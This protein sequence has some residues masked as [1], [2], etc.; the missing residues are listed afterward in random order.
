MAA[1]PS[2]M[3]KMP[4]FA[5][6]IGDTSA[7]SPLT[8]PPAREPDKGVPA[9]EL[10][11]WLEAHG[12][13]LGWYTKDLAM[14]PINALIQQGHT[15]FPGPRYH[16]AQDAVMGFRAILPS[17]REAW[18]H[19]G[20]RRAT[21]PDLLSILRANMSFGVLTRLVLSVHARSETQILHRVDGTSVQDLLSLAGFTARSH[22]APNQLFLVKNESR[23]NRNAKKSAP[24]TLF[25]LWEP[26]SSSQMAFMD[27]ARFRGLTVRQ[28][29]ITSLDF[30][31]D[32]APLQQNVCVRIPAIIPEELLRAVNKSRVRWLISF[33][34]AHDLYLWPCPQGPMPSD[35]PVL[36]WSNGHAQ[37]H[38]DEVAELREQLLLS[39][40]PN[41]VMH[42]IGADHNSV[43]DSKSLQED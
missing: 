22:F 24:W 8:D 10:E 18:N 32:F 39:I 28:E 29:T 23:R 38:H 33:K 6:D 16:C 3:S 31:D 37:K 36:L 13:T 20:P 5:S 12:W 30:I 42:L 14:I 9:G 27:R 41:G 43:I 1:W 17:G 35:D 34:S 26:N 25:V 4:P 11:T 2:F 21:G 40:D 7:A 15:G 19:T